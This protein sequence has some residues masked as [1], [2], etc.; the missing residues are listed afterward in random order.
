M[1]HCIRRRSPVT[2]LPLFNTSVTPLQAGDSEFAFGFYP[3]PS[4]PNVFSLKPCSI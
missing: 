3:P 4:N 1:S 2:P